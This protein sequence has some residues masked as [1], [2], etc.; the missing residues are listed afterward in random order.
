MGLY[1]EVLYVLAVNSQEREQSKLAAESVVKDGGRLK[2]AWYNMS[3][4]I[5]KDKPA[6]LFYW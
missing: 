2:R 3:A 5:Q 6:V 4:I 1:N